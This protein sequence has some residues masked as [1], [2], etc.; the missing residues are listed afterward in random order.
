M[1]ENYRIKEAMI[2][3]LYITT[4]TIKSNTIKKNLRLL[5]IYRKVY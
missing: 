3:N 4:K 5:K 1:K 2:K